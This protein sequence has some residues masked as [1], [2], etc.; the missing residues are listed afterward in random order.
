MNLDT[1]LKLQA[2]VDGELTE[3]E[4]REVAAWLVRDSE[5][6]SLCEEI[7]GINRVLDLDELEVKVPESREF[8][9]SKIEQDIAQSAASE[10]ERP[11]VGGYAWWMRIFA[12]A[13]G[14]ALVLMTTLTLVRHSSHSPSMASYPLEIE[15]PLEDTSTISFHSPSA[16]MTVVWVQSAVY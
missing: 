16:G 15:T 12:P 9:W 14:V 5:A 10:I 3:T 2:Y 4:S 6:Q 11:T 1:K 8:Y 7:K 13:L